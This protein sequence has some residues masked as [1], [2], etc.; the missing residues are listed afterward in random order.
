MQA[1]GDKAL[2]HEGSTKEFSEGRFCVANE[3]RS[4]EE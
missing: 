4:E 2:Q 3:K 1:S